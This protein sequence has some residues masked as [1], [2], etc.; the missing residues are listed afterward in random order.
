MCSEL[1]KNPINQTNIQQT[2]LNR[3]S[4]ATHSINSLTFLH[5]VYEWSLYTESTET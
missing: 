5:L 1:I 2:L 3:E 4:K